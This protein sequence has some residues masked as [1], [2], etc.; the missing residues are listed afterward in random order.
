MGLNNL[1]NLSDLAKVAKG[2][3]ANE[4]LT[5]PVDDVIS[6]VQ[7]RKRFKNIEELAASLK[8]EG[9]QSPII[10]SPKNENGKYVIQ[11]GERRWRACKEAN[12]ENITLIVNNKDLNYIDEIAGELIENIQRDDLTPIEIAEAMKEFINEGWKQK[13]IAVRIG[14]NISFV[15]SHLALLKIPDCVKNLYENEITSDTETLNNLRLLFDIDNDKCRKI[16]ETSMLEG[17]TRKQSRELLNDAKQVKKDI[18]LKNIPNSIIEPSVNE[19][20]KDIEAQDVSSTLTS[21]D[22]SIIDQVEEAEPVESVEQE[23]DTTLS[24]NDQQW[25]KVKP[26]KIIFKIHILLDDEISTGIILTD[27]IS[28]EQSHVWVKIM[29]GERKDQVTQVP[30]SNIELLSIY[31]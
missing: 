12:I 14:K 5:V 31:S 10:V 6:K 30:L 24:E 16:C 13:D 20:N 27:R 21:S 23:I 17:I 18:K 11:K 25:K 7:V 3:K 1:R 2:S 29:D 8:S 9:Q 15:S 28:L 22:E 4:I 19:Y 26:E